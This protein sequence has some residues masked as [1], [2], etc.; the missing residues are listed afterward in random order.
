MVPSA[1]NEIPLP[2]Y[3]K[4]K[5][6]ELSFQVSNRLG[7]CSGDELMLLLH[8]EEHG[9]A[10]TIKEAEIW[11]LKDNRAVAAIQDA[12]ARNPD[13]N[14]WANPRADNSN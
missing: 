8:F 14:A 2:E 6:T 13:A 12:L 10:S 1:S 11:R 5:R 7:V 9:L 4:R 3:E